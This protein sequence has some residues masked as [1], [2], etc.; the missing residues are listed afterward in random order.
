MPPARDPT[1]PISI[2]LD[3]KY[4]INNNNM[5]E[6]LLIPAIAGSLVEAN[7]TK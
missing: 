3:A 4:E 1:T 5:V 6:I 2:N 7:V